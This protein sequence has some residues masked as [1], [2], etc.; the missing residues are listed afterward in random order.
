MNYQ[1]VPCEEYES[2]YEDYDLQKENIVDAIYVKAKLEIDEGNPYIEALPYPRNEENI[3]MAY[4]SLLSS[5]RYDKVK[6]MSKFEKMLQVGM[7]RELRFPL[8][9]H[10]KL[11]FNFYDALIRS[12][13]A[14]RPIE[15]RKSNVEYVA[16]NTKLMT[17]RKLSGDSAAS[18][19]AGFSLIGY[20]G[21]GKS[22]AINTLVSRYPQV[23]MHDDENGGYF[24]Q[25]VYLVVNCIPNSNFAALYEGIGDAIDQAFGNTTPIYATEIAHAAGLGKKAEKVKNLIE[26]FGIGMI[27]FDEIQLIDFQHTKE[28][29][30]DSLLTLA[31]RTKV[32]IAVV[33][34]EDA[35]DKMFKELR[36]A[37][38][39]GTMINANSYCARKDFF[40][41]LVEELFHYQW[42]DEPVEV[43]DEIVDVLYDVTKG[44]VD[45]LIGVYACMNYDYLDKKKKPVVNAEYI[46]K[47][48][49]NYYPGMQEVLAN[50]ESLENERKMLE[51]RAESDAQIAKMM[52]QAQQELEME[53]IKQKKTSMAAN[54]ATL[55]NVIANI[56][57]IYDE[58]S[59]KQIE[60]AFWNVT[61]DKNAP[62][63][64]RAITKAVIQEL[65]KPKKKKKSGS[66][67]VKP[68]MQHIQSFVNDGDNK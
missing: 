66:Q 41:F 11:E 29:T 31:N 59:T 45:Q 28:N 26:R 48:A 60:N 53:K 27:I 62:K 52:D 4:T 22:S 25:I 14:R 55:Q 16:S 54:L 13:R 56:T 40:E 39:I 18:T 7:L 19:D 1:Y 36:T 15:S 61:K 64:E 3:N 24:P 2:Q 68:D 30:F 9:F 10:K 38:R 44:I 57:N 63:E 50:L 49:K 43:T 32:A 42:F 20:S 35:R 6:N 65:Q 23:I 46:K 8:P 34:T 58:Y 17:N 12:Y 37:R 67:I 33:G 51:I 5:Y 21:C 47:I